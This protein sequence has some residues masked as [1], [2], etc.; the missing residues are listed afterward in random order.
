MGTGDNDK[1]DAGVK[2]T[3]EQQEIVNKLVGGA[4][5]AGKDAALKEYGDYDAVKKRL[6]ELE[7]SGKSEVEKLRNEKERIEKDRKKLL[8][9]N[10]TL[11]QFKAQTEREKTIIDR[12]TALKFPQTYAKYAKGETAE[13]IDASLKAVHADFG[14]RDIGA[15]GGGGEGDTSGKKSENEVMN[16]M[17]YK[18]AG[19]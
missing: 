15:G 16:R 8:D 7:D 3:P 12:C 5:A 11:T 17:I 9:E 13:E 14:A 10:K 6:A 4:R 19:G 2:F 18:K 1:G